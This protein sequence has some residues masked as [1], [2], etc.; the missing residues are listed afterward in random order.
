MPKYLEGLLGDVGT[1]SPDD[2]VACCF[3]LLFSAEGP[4]DI[5][6]ATV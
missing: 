1:S 4:T 6:G 2:A 3:W 5:V